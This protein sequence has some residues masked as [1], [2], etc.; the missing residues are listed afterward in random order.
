MQ[1]RTSDSLEVN[2]RSN[3]LNAFA[4]RF[5]LSI[6]SECLDR[7]VPLSEG[8]PATMRIGIREAL[9]RRAEPPGSLQRA[10]PVRAKSGEHEWSGLTS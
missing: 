10:N 7:I 2:V 6:R 5:V 8:A 4:E 3:S 9:P 1:S